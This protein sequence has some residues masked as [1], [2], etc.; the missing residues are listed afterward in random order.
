MNVSKIQTLNMPLLKS[1]MTYTFRI[2]SYAS[3]NLSRLEQSYL[4]IFTTEPE[5]LY[6]KAYF[7]PE[8]ESSINERVSFSK[9]ENFN[10]SQ[11]LKPK[12]LIKASFLVQKTA[13]ISDFSKKQSIY[14][15]SSSLKKSP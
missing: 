15:S 8:T 9:Q 6:E 1:N 3:K 7:L 5:K 13:N 12:R 4:Y 14:E 11:I 2:C 10:P